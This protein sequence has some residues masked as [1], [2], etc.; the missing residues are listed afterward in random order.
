MKIWDWLRKKR[1]QPDEL[2]EEAGGEMLTE[3]TLD[4]DDVN[5][6]DEIQRRK[7]VE[8][9]LEQI[10]AA[11]DE[12]EQL[13]QEYRTVDSYL[14]DMEE[15][16]M[17][18]GEDK[19]LLE[20][21][22]RKVSYLSKDSYQ[23]EDKKHKLKMADFKKMRRLEEE[24]EEGIAKLREAEQYQDAIRQDLKRLEGEKQACL[25][26]QSEA[27]IA[28]NN[29]RGMAVILV[30]AI[31]VCLIVLLFLQFGLKLDA[32]IGYV[33][34][35]LGAAIALLT[36]Y[37]RFIENKR[38]LQTVSVSLNKLILLQNRVKIRYVNN[39]NLLD[40]L[41]LKYE[42]PS[43]DSMEK[44]WKQYQEEKEERMHMQQILSE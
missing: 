18:E 31:F 25:Y 30:C 44:L 9:C 5:M 39:T 7:Y 15:I 34:V 42:I 1:I 19:A 37:F 35:M 27:S 16:E 17:L 2:Y 38:E 36:I 26:R 40:Y 14:K 32:S 3:Q 33:L 24:A 11:S 43:A 20:D 10:A 23:Y 6:H 12:I 41:Y 8:S 29:Y 21:H 4:R 22:A 28:L 13:E